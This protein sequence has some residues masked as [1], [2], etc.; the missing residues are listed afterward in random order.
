MQKLKPSYIVNEDKKWSGT[1]EN[2]LLAPQK[3]EP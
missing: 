1:M 2:S 3:G